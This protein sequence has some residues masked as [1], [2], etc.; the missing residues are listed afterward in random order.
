MIIIVVKRRKKTQKLKS[1]SV[2]L[3]QES[4]IAKYQSSS[5]ILHKD[6]GISE[7]G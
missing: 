3:Q 1:T 2:M 7:R 4:F 6:H 5:K